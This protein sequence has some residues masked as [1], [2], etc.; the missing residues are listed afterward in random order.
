VLASAIHNALRSL[1][2]EVRCG[3]SS[4]GCELVGN[5]ITGIA[6]HIGLRATSIAAP[7]EVLVSQ[8]VRDPVVAPAGS[9]EYGTYTPGSVPMSGAGS[10]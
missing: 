5:D 2:G 9:L 10:V 4:G 1:N 8:T 7:G 6:V 3:V